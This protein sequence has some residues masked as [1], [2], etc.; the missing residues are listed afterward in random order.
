M[1]LSIFLAKKMTI[2][3]F[4]LDKGRKQNSK[5]NI[6]RRLGAIAKLGRKP[7][8]P[9]IPHAWRPR[10]SS[11]M[12]C[13]ISPGCQPTFELIKIQKPQ[14]QQQKVSS[15][16]NLFCRYVYFS[17]PIMNNQEGKREEKKKII[18]TPYVVEGL[19]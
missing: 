10:A 19:M 11:Q 1:F 13:G 9:N 16:I 6:Y 15:L 17:C 7:H 18:E 14:K 12:F 2:S 4:P 3:F 5:N 8:K